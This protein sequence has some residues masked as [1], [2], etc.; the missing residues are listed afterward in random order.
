MASW[1]VI[2]EARGPG[3]NTLALSRVVSR[4]ERDTYYISD[5]YFW[6]SFDWGNKES[7]ENASCNPFAVA[8]DIGTGNG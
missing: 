2:L 1:V 3:V 5:G 6:K 7:H 8:F 4:G